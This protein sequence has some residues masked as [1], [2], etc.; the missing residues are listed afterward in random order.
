MR[1]EL[2]RNGRNRAARNVNFPSVGSPKAMIPL[3]WVE[4]L[5]DR[6]NTLL[7]EKPH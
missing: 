3:T 7:K 6:A 5:S 2:A 1:W 4:A